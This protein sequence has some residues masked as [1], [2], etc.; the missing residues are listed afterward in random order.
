MKQVT[1]VAIAALTLFTAA[2]VFA[3]TDAQKSFAQLKSLAGSWEGKG[4]DGMPLEVSYKVMS[5]GS[6]VMSEITAHGSNMLTVFH[7]DGPNKLIMTH[8]CSAGNQPRMQGS[9]SADGKSLTFDFLDA[10]SLASAD[11][12]HMHHLTIA[13]PDPNHHTEEW[14]FVDHGKEK[15]ELFDLRRKM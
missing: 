6:A 5:G 14:T 10:T 7:L 12:G 2:S 15:T 13:V 9:M 8:Y 4:P 3:Q 1:R 11:A